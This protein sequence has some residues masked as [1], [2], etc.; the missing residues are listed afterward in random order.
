MLACVRYLVSMYE[1][2]N[3]TLEVYLNANNNATDVHFLKKFRQTPKMGLTMKCHVVLICCSMGEIFTTY[4][5]HYD[6]SNALEYLNSI[7]LH[8]RCIRI[9]NLLDA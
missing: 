3:P 9:F 2:C 4:Q 1:R 7:Q 5:S 8:T 6:D